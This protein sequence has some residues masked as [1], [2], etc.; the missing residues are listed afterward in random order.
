MVDRKAKQEASIIK[1]QAEPLV[2]AGFL[3]GLLFDSADGVN[4]FL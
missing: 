1:Q 2:S 4:V 3:F